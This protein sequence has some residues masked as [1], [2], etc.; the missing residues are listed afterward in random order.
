MRT[1]VI[2]TLAAAVVMTAAPAFAQRAPSLADRVTALE[3]RGQDTSA[4][5]QLQQQVQLL[6]EEVRELRGQLEQ[7]QHAQEQARESARVQYLD[8]DGRLE[9]LEGGA[10]ASP[11]PSTSAAPVSVVTA[12]ASSQTALPRAS[13]E[14]RGAYSAAYALLQAGRYVDASRA[15]S[16]F[17]REQSN[18]ELTPNAVYWLGESYYV[19]QNYPFALEQFNALQQRWPQHDKAPGAMLKSAMSQHGLQ[20]LDDAERGYRAVIAQHPGSDVARIA[21]QRLQTLER[22]R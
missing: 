5:V 17:L 8:L 12:P 3:L 4:Q 9:R 2:A 10:P 19:T 7:L 21:E 15:F 18:N 16:A 20:R 22:Q 14:Q 6:I 13:T 11:A 1:F